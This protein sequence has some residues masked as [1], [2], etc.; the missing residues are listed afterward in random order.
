M[1][2]L[3][4]EGLKS[5]VF[6]S[7]IDKNTVIIAMLRLMLELFNLQTTDT[8]RLLQRRYRIAQ[9]QY[10]RLERF[11]I[12]WQRGGNRH[13]RSLTERNEWE[14]WILFM[15]RAVESTSRLTCERIIAIEKLMQEAAEKAENFLPKVQVAG[16][17]EV[18]FRHPYC[19]VKFLEEAGLGSR[20]TCTKYLRALVEAGLLREQQVWRENYFIND[21][22]FNILTR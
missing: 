4:I 1:S 13:A 2:H 18:V 19:K 16:I 8:Q 22:F 15:L 3:I 12:V 20:P 7:F 21:A 6:L 9:L 5:N 17:L 10:Q 11:G 14:S